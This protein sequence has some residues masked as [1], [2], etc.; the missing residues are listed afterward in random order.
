M[1]CEKC[2]SQ[3]EPNAVFCGSCGAKVEAPAEAA[4]VAEA[5]VVEAP[6]VE[7]PVAEAPAAGAIDTPFGPVAKEKAIGIA[8]IAAGVV[9][10][11]LLIGLIFGG[12]ARKTAK[13]Y[14]D[15][16][17]KGNARAIVNS[18]P[19]KVLNEILDEE[20]MEKKE[21]IEEIEDSLEYVE[22]ELDDEYRRWRVV[23]KVIDENKIVGDALENLQDRYDDVFDVKVSAAKYVTVKMTLKTEE[24]PEWS[25]QRVRMIK[26]GGKWYLDYYNID[27][28]Y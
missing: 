12:G 11:L 18:I 16:V 1:F 22:E 5:P 23:T 27:L 4:P 10:V 7:T 25:Y 13:K 20:N 17:Y 15:A 8:A 9:V 21:L 3:L 24:D 6:V 2:G 19:R 26:V 14:V 28:P